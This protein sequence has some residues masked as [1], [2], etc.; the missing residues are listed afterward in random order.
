MPVADLKFRTSVVGFDLV[1]GIIGTVS[2]IFNSK[3][4][5]VRTNDSSFDGT[6][7]SRSSFIKP[8]CKGVCLDIK[9]IRY[10]DH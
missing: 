3:F 10:L 9:K 6:N 4:R 1:S 2:S 7:R 8:I 5:I